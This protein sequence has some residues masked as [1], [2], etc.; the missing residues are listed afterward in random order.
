[1]PLLLNR[2]YLCHC[3]SYKT[4]DFICAHQNV[5]NHECCCHRGGWRHC[6]NIDLPLKCSQS[7]KDLGSHGSQESPMRHRPCLCCN[8]LESEDLFT[9]AK[10]WT[11]SNKALNWIY[12]P[13]KWTWATPHYF[14]QYESANLKYNRRF[15]KPYGKGSSWQTFWGVFV[16]VSLHLFMWYGLL[17]SQNLKFSKYPGRGWSSA[18]GNHSR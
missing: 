15:S 17:T 1:M 5:S 7:H 13:L 16:V 14:F 12:W 6:V 18:A 2:K 8:D 10:R 4:S 11:F 9:A 3:F